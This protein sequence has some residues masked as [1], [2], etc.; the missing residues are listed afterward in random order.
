MAKK[1][2]V[3]VSR[4]FGR[5][6]TTVPRDVRERLGL[7]DGDRILWYINDRDEVCVAR[8]PRR[9]ELDLEVLMP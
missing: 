5:G 1:I 4:V 3:A 9:E 8:I 6:K 7:R 2:E